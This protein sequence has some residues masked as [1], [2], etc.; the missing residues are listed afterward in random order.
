[1]VE[2]WAVLDASEFKLV[3][4]RTRDDIHPRRLAR[5]ASFSLL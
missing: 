5:V 4:A 3:E 1:M 2:G